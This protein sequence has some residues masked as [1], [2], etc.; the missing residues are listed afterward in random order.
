MYFWHYTIW[1]DR[2]TNEICPTEKEGYILKMLDK[3][4]YLV[5]LTKPYQEKMW[6]NSNELNT[7]TPIF[8]HINDDDCSLNSE[9]TDYYTIGFTYDDTEPF[10]S[11]V[12]RKRKCMAMCH[13]NIIKVLDERKAEIEKSISK[14]KYLNRFGGNEDN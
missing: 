2:D 12:T 4:I 14:L 8:E 9:G 5:E 1:F 3:A 11:I 7:S 13:E 10:S 6:I